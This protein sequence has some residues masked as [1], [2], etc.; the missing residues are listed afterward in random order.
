MTKA[1]QSFGTESLPATMRVNVLAS[2]GLMRP[3]QRPVPRPA[4]DQVLVRIGSVGI[5]GA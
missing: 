4:N 1:A 2:A 5:C 3:E